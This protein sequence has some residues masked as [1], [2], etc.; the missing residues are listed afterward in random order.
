MMGIGFDEDN[1]D[2]PKYSIWKVHV[3]IDL[4]AEKEKWIPNKANKDNFDDDVFISFWFQPFQQ[5]SVKNRW[6]LGEMLEEHRNSTV[7]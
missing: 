4:E 3:D 7:E 2:A 6:E 5:V 1:K